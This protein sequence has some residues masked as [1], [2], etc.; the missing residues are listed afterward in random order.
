MV[1]VSSQMPPHLK[2]TLA[3]SFIGAF[4]GEPVL[5]SRNTSKEAPKQ[6]ESVH[7]AIH[8]RYPL[9]VSVD[10]YTFS[11]TVLTSHI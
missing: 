3:E 11:H 4:N 7:Y 1:F 6:F 8:N 10:V 2:K 9:R 5:A